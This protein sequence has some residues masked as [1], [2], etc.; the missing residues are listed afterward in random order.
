MF[1]ITAHFPNAE[2]II[3]PGM[4]CCYSVQ[5]IPDTLADYDDIIKVNQIN[6][7]C[8]HTCRYTCC[9]CT[10]T[11]HIHV[12]MYTHVHTVHTHTCRA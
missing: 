6:T 12:D 2:G 1:I 8:T 4:S 9:T 5:F 11:L 10:C 3:A 7:Y